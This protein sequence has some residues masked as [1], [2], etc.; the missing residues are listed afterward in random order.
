M[1]RASS[2]SKLSPWLTAKM[3]MGVVPG[4]V[5]LGVAHLRWCWQ[6]A[7]R[8]C[9]SAET[10]KRQR[11]I[12]HKLLMPSLGNS[13]HPQRRMRCAPPPTPRVAAVKELYLVPPAVEEFTCGLKPFPKSEKK[14]TNI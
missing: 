6:D 12:D 11:G 3:V 4:L 1:V 13:D 14:E 5:T 9:P 8:T 7:E 10:R 2:P